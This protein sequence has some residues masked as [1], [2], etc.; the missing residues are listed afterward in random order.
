MEEH[1]KDLETCLDI[2]ILTM[3]VN[4]L[5]FPQQNDYVQ[6]AYEIHRMDMFTT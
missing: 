6:R 3:G 4:I 1:I 5:Y 2:F